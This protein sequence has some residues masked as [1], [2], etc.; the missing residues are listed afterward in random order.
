MIP[1][2]TKTLPGLGGPERLLAEISISPSSPFEPFSSWYPDN[3]WLATTD[4]AENGKGKPNEYAIFLISHETGERRQITQPPARLIGD[5]NPAFSPDGKSLAFV[6]S[7]GHGVSE[8]FVVP[9]SP[10]LAASGPPKRLISEK[11]SI[12]RPVWTADGSHII[13]GVEV[14]AGSL[15]QIAASGG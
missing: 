14:S 11:K 2:K 4:L 8:L 15:W 10:Q 1:R 3:K 6:R 13:Y 5:S 12:V 7:L 9:I